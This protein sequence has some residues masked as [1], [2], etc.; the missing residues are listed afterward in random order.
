MVSSSLPSSIRNWLQETFSAI[1]LP[2]QVDFWGQDKLNTQMASDRPPLTLQIHHPGV[3]RAMFLRQDPLVLADAYMNGFFDFA[4]GTEELI[5]LVKR[6][7]SLGVKRSQAIAAWASA[8]MLPRLPLALRSGVNRQ[9]WFT[10]TEQR[11][12]QVI[13]YH[14]DVG[15]S[16]YRLWL[17]PEMV[18]SCAHFDH[19]DLSLEAAQTAKLDLICRKLRLAP[20][21]TLL[22]I[23]C[24]WGA[25]LR[26]AATHYGVKGHGITLSQEQLDFNRQRLEAEGLNDQIQVELLDYRNLPQTP[27]F[28]KIVSIGMVE[29]VGLKNYPTYFQSALSALKPGGLFLNHGITSSDR[30][31]GTSLGERFIHRYI[32]PDGQLTRLSTLLTVAEEAGWEIVDVDAWRPHYA[33]TLRHWANNFDQVIEALKAEVGDRKAQLWQLYLIGSAVGF[34]ENQMGIYQTLLRPK[35]DTHWNLPLTRAKWL[36]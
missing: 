9:G 35:A 34:E 11:D 24:G 1:P 31:R 36:C 25:L 2:L 28:D 23:G 5:L 3:V 21:E 7:S 13:Q 26:W 29:H 15:N 32:F 10:H 33:K 6:L 19:P 8:L 30:W 18:Y 12:R 17:D 14:Y 20:G 4:G 16:F 27:T 22:D